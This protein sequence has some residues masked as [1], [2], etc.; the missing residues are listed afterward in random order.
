MTDFTDPGWRPALPLVGR[1]LSGRGPDGSILLVMR[2]GVILLGA[3]A[4]AAAIAALVFGAGTQEPR[5][6]STVARI[7]ISA[8]MGGGAI[9]VSLTGT[10]GPDMDSEGHL[11]VSVF[12][13]TMRRVLYAAAIGPAGLAISWLSSDGSYVIFGTGL[14]LLFMAVGGPTSKRVAQFQAEVDEAG[15]DLSVIRALHRSYR[16]GLSST[17]SAPI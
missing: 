12:T 6:S 1:I 9:G 4:V 16:C 5:I 13:V 8:A 14:A 17:S 7:L 11:A 15:S 2:A 10:G 3:V